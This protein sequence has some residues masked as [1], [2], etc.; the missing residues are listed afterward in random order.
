[1]VNK[2]IVTNFNLLERA[3]KS[4]EKDPQT[5]TRSNTQTHS[6]THSHRHSDIDRQ[7][8]SDIQTHTHIDT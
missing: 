2:I 1:M 6:V 4:T 7:T 3:R 8:V 5:D